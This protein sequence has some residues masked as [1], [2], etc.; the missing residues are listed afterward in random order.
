MPAQTT[1]NPRSNAGSEYDQRRLSFMDKDASKPSSSPSGAA[2][3]TESATPMAIKSKK[4][5]LQ[6]WKLASLND[7]LPADLRP[8]NWSEH[9]LACLDT[10]SKHESLRDAREMLADQVRRRIRDD[11]AQKTDVLGYLTK[12]DADEVVRQCRNHPRSSS[13][14]EVSED[15]RNETPL[16]VDAHVEQP[17]PEARVQTD[18]VHTETTQTEDADAGVPMD[19]DD[20]P[21]QD[22]IVCITLGSEASDSS[23]ETTPSTPHKFEKA[24]KAKKPASHVR[25]KK[26]AKPEKSKK[27]A[28]VATKE[29][30]TAAPAANG[31][32]AGAASTPV[33]NTL[34]KSTTKN[35]IG[36]G[37]RGS[38]GTP[39]PNSPTKRDGAPQ[40]AASQ[41]KGKSP[42]STNRGAAIQDVD[43]YDFASSEPQGRPVPSP[44]R[45]RAHPPSNGTAATGHEAL[46]ATATPRRQ[47][48]NFISRTK[49]SS[50]S[51]ATAIFH[52]CS[53]GSSSSRITRSWYYLFAEHTQAGDGLRSP[54]GLSRQRFKH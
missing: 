40:T 37:L 51:Y 31:S 3:T 45:P 26:A 2:K 5:I 39:T 25:A 17:A 32:G 42:A 7:I 54:L 35:S 50:L 15:T 4:R 33:N 10:L 43:L 20:D 18:M 19:V 36:N 28:P 44:S 8:P 11:R 27:R 22:S 52:S 46:K 6:K 13:S 14:R 24:E 47:A 38:G 16:S 53:A 23:G 34:L 12:R 48:G 1:P 21:I 30:A 49:G 41:Q 9:I 29:S